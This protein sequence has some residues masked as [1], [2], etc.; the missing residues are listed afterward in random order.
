MW[1]VLRA[2]L[3]LILGYAVVFLE[4]TA[5]VYSF[6]Q[7]EASELVELTVWGFS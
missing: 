4:L 7:A 5:C 3:A 6:V 2:F 1:F